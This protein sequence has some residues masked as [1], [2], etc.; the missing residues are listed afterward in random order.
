MRDCYKYVIE[1]DGK[2]LYPQKPPKE[3]A[4]CEP[5]SIKDPSILRTKELFTEI[6]LE[7]LERLIKSTTP[8]EYEPMKLP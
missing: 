2:Y 3:E 7:E 5:L 1:Y 4:I 6:E 8:Y